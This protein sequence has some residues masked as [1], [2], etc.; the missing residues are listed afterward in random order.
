MN[1][2]KNFAFLLFAVAAFASC[3]GPSG[4]Y[5]GTDYMP[6]MG[7]SVANEANVY[8]NY[9]ANSWDEQSVIS[10]KETSMPRLP[11]KGTIPRGYAGYALSANP[12]G[13]LALLN[14]ETSV[15]AIS[16]PINGDVP[17]YYAD[18]DDDRARAIREIVKNPF[19]ISAA[20]IERGKNL[21]TI[22]CGICHGDK[23]DGSGYLVRDNDGKYPAQPANLVN[24]EFTAA[25]E[26]RFYHA[27]IYGKNAMGGYADKLSYE[28]RWDVMHYIRS[29]QAGAKG[30]K[31]D[32]NEN[33]FNN[34][35][36]ASKV[37]KAAVKEVVSEAA[38]KVADT[39]K[40]VESH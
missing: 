12:D 38:V 34:A 18:T 10:R 37:V 16:T 15:H 29:L 14:G 22:Y 32:E 25:S 2:L 5:P 13:T 31:Y 17:Y 23:A 19:P 24:D 35:T 21:Y 3:S 36:P 28:E 7:Y 4:N 8:N 30:L 40:K 1:T 39:N 11:V 9:W 20:A 6:D 33:T 27:I 26:G